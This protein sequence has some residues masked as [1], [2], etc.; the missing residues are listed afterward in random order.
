MNFYTAYRIYMSY[1]FFRCVSNVLFPSCRR[2]YCCWI[3]I[4]LPYVILHQ[5][6][7]FLYSESTRWKTKLSAY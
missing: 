1:I 5:L 6:V 2:S 4:D 3:P 7:L